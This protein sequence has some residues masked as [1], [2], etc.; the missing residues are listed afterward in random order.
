MICVNFLSVLTQLQQIHTLHPS[1]PFRRF[2][3]HVRSFP[4][5][6]GFRISLLFLTDTLIGE[7]APTLGNFWS[8]FMQ[9]QEAV[10][11]A[12][13]WSFG[14]CASDE[15]VWSPPDHTQKPYVGP[16]LSAQFSLPSTPHPGILSPRP[17][18]GWALTYLNLS[19]NITLSQ[20]TFLLC[21]KINYSCISNLALILH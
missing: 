6:P 5:K 4:L 7:C 2:T 18:Y 21:S 16:S 19:V 17:L 12:R 14:T 9:E 13:L 15:Y 11:C 8:W 10:P 1:P 3:E 20:R